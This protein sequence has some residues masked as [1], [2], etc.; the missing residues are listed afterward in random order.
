MATDKDK[1]MLLKN[2][3]ADISLLQF[4]G[5]SA[6]ESFSQTDNDALWES[7][8]NSDTNELLSE[9]DSP[10]CNYW[11]FSLAT[12]GPILDIS[13]SLNKVTCLIKNEQF[14]DEEYNGS[15]ET[16]LMEEVGMYEDLTSIDIMT[17]ARHGWRKNAKDTSVVAIGEKMH[18]RHE[19]LGTQRIYN[20]LDDNDVKV[21]IHSH[22]RNMSINKF[23]R[24]SDVVN[25]NDSWHEIKAV[26]SAMNK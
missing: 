19:K 10:C 24:D 2:N 18:K 3:Q 12:E 25:Q 16:A 17:D 22:D 7:E 23:V 20:Y 9:M 15:I 5:N 1:L 4:G 8:E 11:D 14:I 6:N 21:G 13:T 26:K